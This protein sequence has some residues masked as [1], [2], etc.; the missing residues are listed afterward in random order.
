V[1]KGLRAYS[2]IEVLYWLHLSRRDLVLR[3]PANDGDARGTFSLRSP[4]RPIRSAPRSRWFNELTVVRF[5]V[6]G[7]DCIDETPLLNP[8]A[9]SLKPQ[10]SSLKPQASSLTERCSH[11]S[12]RRRLEIFKSVTREALILACKP[13]AQPDPPGNQDGAEDDLA[14]NIRSICPT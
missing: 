9:S 10:A 13:G 7:L 6:G 4:A 12:H 2:R 5:C 8:Q 1:L 14:L 11:R 3:S